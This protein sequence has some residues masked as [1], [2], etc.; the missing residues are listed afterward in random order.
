MRIGRFPHQPV[1]FRI[2]QQTPPRGGAM[3]SRG[4]AAEGARFRVGVCGVHRSRE[5]A[6]SGGG[7][8]GAATCPASR[9]SRWPG[10]LAAAGPRLTPTGMSAAG[11]LG[12]GALRL[13]ALAGPRPRAWNAVRSGAALRGGLLTW[14][15]ISPPISLKCV[16]FYLSHIGS[17][18]PNS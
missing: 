10:G 4:P 6:R 9:V 14:A 5:L 3:R 11:G 16:H 2:P 1:P 17:H 13:G 15:G 12:P 8:G 7:G 18:K